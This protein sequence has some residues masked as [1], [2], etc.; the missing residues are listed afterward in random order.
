MY[1]GFF[2]NFGSKSFERDPKRPREFRHNQLP[3]KSPVKLSRYFHWQSID[4][5]AVDSGK[6][7]TNAS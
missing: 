1:A 5:T 7:V 2:A 3:H 4:S 6:T